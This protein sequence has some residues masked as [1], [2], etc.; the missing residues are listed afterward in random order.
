MSPDKTSYRLY[1][2]SSKFPNLYLYAWNGYKSSDWPGD[3]LTNTADVS[4]YGS[5]LYV[6]IP[7]G[8]GLY[9]FII[10]GGN[11]T[12]QTADLTPSNAIVL[13]T[14]DFLYEWK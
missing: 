4:G 3:K 1:I 12:G 7:M 2:K 5:C 8:K 11:G 10:N 14:G 13:S 9:N 6:D